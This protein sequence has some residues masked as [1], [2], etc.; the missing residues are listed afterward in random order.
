MNC[1]PAKI[2]NSVGHSVFWGKANKTK[3]LSQLTYGLTFPYGLIYIPVG[4]LRHRTSQF[5][6][7]VGLFLVDK[8][9]NLEYC[10]NVQ[11]LEFNE[12]NMRLSKT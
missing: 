6:K 12:H 5:E 11:T 1:D 8:S 9:D 7:L 10:E 3:I 4:L 2:G